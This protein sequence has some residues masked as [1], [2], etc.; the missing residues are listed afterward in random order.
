MKAKDLKKILATVDDDAV[1]V[2]AAG[3]H[4]YCECGLHLATGL[5]DGY[6]DAWTE[7]HGESITPEADYG[8][9]LPVLIVR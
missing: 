1:L 8:K 2:R 6:E 3:D 7:D 9:R 5:Y 4:S